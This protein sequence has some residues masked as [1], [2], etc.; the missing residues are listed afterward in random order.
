MDLER[1]QDGWWITGLPD[2]PD[3]GP[4][5]RKADAASDRRGMKRFF[6]YQDERE[7]FTMEPPPVDGQRGYAERTAFWR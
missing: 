6:R 5:D 3:C 2:G 1:R 7:F 4:Y